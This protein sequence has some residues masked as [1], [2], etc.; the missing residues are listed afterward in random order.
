MG[1]FL[2]ADCIDCR[3][4]VAASVCTEFRPVVPNH[5][6]GDFWMRQG[7]FLH[8][9]AHGICFCHISFHEF[10]THRNVIEQIPD[11]QRGSVRTAGLFRFS[12]HTAGN[13]KAGAVG[14][15]PAFGED[16]NL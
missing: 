11:N 8:D 1:K 3:I 13:L 12:R 14:I 5:A 15:L 2:A 4:K 6:K 16:R 10:L 7:D 9:L